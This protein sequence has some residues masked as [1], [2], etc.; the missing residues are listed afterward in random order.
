MYLGE[1]AKTLKINNLEE[2]FTGEQDR[3]FQPVFQCS[4]S[5]YGLLNNL[6]NAKSLYEHRGI[7]IPNVNISVIFKEGEEIKQTEYIAELLEDEGINVFNE[8]IYA[9]YVLFHEE[10]HAKDFENSKLTPEQ[11]ID[12]DV[13]DRYDLELQK[14]KI[15]NAKPEEIELQTDLF[16][17]KY[18]MMK[19]ERIANEYAI[20]KIVDEIDT[21]LQIGKEL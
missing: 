2:I 4:S 13:I 18:N 6:Y 17:L 1:L 9:S 12:R 8:I 21:I 7:Y 10:G 15:A 14:E 11:F 16:F 19:P 3:F 5:E 20:K